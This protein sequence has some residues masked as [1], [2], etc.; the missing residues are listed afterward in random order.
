MFKKLNKNKK[1]KANPNLNNP[2]PAQPAKQAVSQ[3]VQKTINQIFSLYGDKISQ[4]SETGIVEQIRSVTTMP[5]KEALKKLQRIAVYLEQ[6]LEVNL[7]KG[8]ANAPKNA[9][10]QNA[11]A[12]KSGKAVQQTINNIL[13]IY[14]KEILELADSTKIVEEITSVTTLPEKEAIE[15]L[16]MVAL[17]IEQLSKKNEPPKPNSAKHGAG[18]GAIVNGAQLGAIANKVNIN[19]KGEKNVKPNVVNDNGK[20]NVKPNAVKNK[21]AKNVK[22]N[23]VKNEGAKNVKPN[24]V[25][26]NPTKFDKIKQ[27]YGDSGKAQDFALLEKLPANFVPAT[28]DK[29]TVRELWDEEEANKLFGVAEN[30]SL[31][32]HGEENVPNDPFNNQFNYLKPGA[33]A[34]KK[35]EGDWHD[36]FRSL[37]DNNGDQ[38]FHQ[39]YGYTTED[40][41]GN[42]H[43]VNPVLRG[44]EP[45]TDIDGEVQTNKL[46]KKPYTNEEIKSYIENIQG[47]ISKFNLKEAIKVSR[48]GYQFGGLSGAQLMEIYGDGKANEADMP[49]ALEEAFSSTSVISDANEKFGNDVENRIL[50][51]I[52]VPAGKG[53]GMYVAPFSNFDDEYEFVL[54]HHSVFKIT[55]VR[56][57]PN[58]SRVIVDADLIGNIA[59][60]YNFKPPT[61]PRY[62]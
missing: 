5:E 4:L 26:K 42:F 46:T 59:D 34:L 52:N 54:Q 7:K 6:P 17:K 41:L 62:E 53:H 40:Y 9:P 30:Q 44:H 43:L 19:N 56:K 25:K 38:Q 11:P 22:P 16:Q 35:P 24:A 36:W 27:E 61:K 31:F 50:I 33:E 29:S 57:D 3:R 13:Q 20:K 18:P 51:N 28:I 23:V 55:N 14:S 8:Q 21:G 10:A 58:N 1:G 39:S 15:K 37:F 49:F 47:A 48:Y 2:L 32:G 45:D 12:K 60:S